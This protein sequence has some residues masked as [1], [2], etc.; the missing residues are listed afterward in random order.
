MTAEQTALAQLKAKFKDGTKVRFDAK[1]REAVKQLIDDYELLL[2]LNKQLI[3]KGDSKFN[4][5]S[6]F[7]D[8]L[9]NK[10]G[11]KDARA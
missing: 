6:R 5:I 1:D 11:G 4:A 8:K 7:I 10:S 2:K 9:V 3:A